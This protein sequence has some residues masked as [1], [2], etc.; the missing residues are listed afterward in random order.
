LGLTSRDLSQELKA[1]GVLANGI[2]PTH[3]RMLTHCDVTR[4]ECER[5]AT[6]LE[7]IAKQKMATTATVW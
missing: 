7:Q 3:M 5:A 2:N 6:V 1:A 4:K